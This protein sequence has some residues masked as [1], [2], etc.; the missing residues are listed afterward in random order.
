MRSSELSEYRP[1][2]SLPAVS[3]NAKARSW[4]V[5]LFT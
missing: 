1:E 3:F 4:S 2:F 5:M